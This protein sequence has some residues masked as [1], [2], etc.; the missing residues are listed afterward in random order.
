MAEQN[1]MLEN[2]IKS[3]GD[4]R[5][6]R[7][8]RYNQ[9]LDPMESAQTMDALQES[10]IEDHAAERISPS[11]APA[12]ISSM[13]IMGGGEA[14]GDAQIQTAAGS[15]DRSTV[16]N[17]QCPGGVCPTTPRQTVVGSTMSMLP[18]VNFAQ[19]GTDSIS[20]IRQYSEN[21]RQAA[22]RANE[23]GYNNTAAGIMAKAAELEV[24]AEQLEQAREG[25]RKGI[26]QAKKV[27]DDSAPARR[28]STFEGRQEIADEYTQR[29]TDIKMKPQNYAN[30]KLA[31]W[32]AD[33]TQATETAG[34]AIPPSEESITEAKQ[35]FL[36]EGYVEQG[37]GLILHANKLKRSTYD[38]V[39]D[40]SPTP[41]HEG[42]MAF[43]DARG[44]FINDGIAAIF[45]GFEENGILTDRK[46][47]DSLLRNTVYPGM[48]IGLTAKHTVGLQ[49][50]TP[51]YEE[52]ESMAAREFGVLRDAMMVQYERRLEQYNQDPSIFTS[53]K[54]MFLGG[55]RNL[56]AVPTYE[57]QRSGEP[58]PKPDPFQ[59][60]PAGA[61]KQ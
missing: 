58:D 5:E 48:L 50:G 52:A 1:G 12:S 61:G 49:E 9:I 53:F 43:A 25:G 14:S 24:S 17:T 2:L 34:G 46:S 41:Q 51:E 8:T 59:F 33:N 32:I 36:A 15:N 56:G 23:R 42:D 13:P 60:I 21:L 44:R 16:T 11:P 30:K 28:Q 47:M 20:N 31:L 45:D 10:S 37:I 26:R 18:P 39:E 22:N 55:N 57:G 7:R 3:M 40:L 29:V 38:D 6:R 35:Q 19:G 27:Y 54:N 4:R